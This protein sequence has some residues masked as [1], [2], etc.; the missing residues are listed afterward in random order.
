MPSSRL[1]FAIKACDRCI[2]APPLVDHASH[3]TRRQENKTPWAYANLL[4]WKLET[5]LIPNGH[6]PN[7]DRNK[8][9]YH[10]DEDKDVFVKRKAISVRQNTNK[11]IL[12]SRCAQLPDRG[13]IG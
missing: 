8:S 9:G 10:I 6:R 4:F 12:F 13:A 2:P 1:S 3:D 11:F 7:S 5:E